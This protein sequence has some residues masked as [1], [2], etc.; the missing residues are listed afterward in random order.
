MERQDIDAVV[1]GVGSGGML[2]GDGMA[3][4]GIIVG[5]ITLTGLAL[6]MTEF[7]E[8]VSQGNV[9]AMLLFIAF[10]C[11]VL[12]LGVPTTANYVLVATLMAPVVVEQLVAAIRGLVGATATVCELT[13]LRVC[14][15]N[16]PN[17][18]PA[19]PAAMSTGTSSA[20]SRWA[21][22]IHTTGPNVLEA[23][24]CIFSGTARIST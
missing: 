2:T 5:A 6:R 17:Q 23:M 4:A 22:S 19:P 12:G 8:F 11:L 3:L 9:I 18:K 14:S 16:L 20:P 24:A 21:V 1:V 15:L 13:G 7:V 10:V